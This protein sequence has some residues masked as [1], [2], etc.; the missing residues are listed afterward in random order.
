MSYRNERFNRSM[1]SLEAMVAGFKDASKAAVF[2]DRGLGVGRMVDEIDA[3]GSGGA[4][5]QHQGNGHLARSPMPGGSLA[6]VERARRPFPWIWGSRRERLLAAERKLRRAGLGH[7][8]PTLRLIVRNGNN[9]Q[10][11]IGEM[12]NGTESTKAARKRYER[13]RA[14]LLAFFDVA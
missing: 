3:N 14:Q 10:E 11:S 5:G 13:H 12:T 8:V 7:L 2:S 9:R 4:N 6:S 1:M